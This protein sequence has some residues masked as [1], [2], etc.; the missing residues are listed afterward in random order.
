MAKV[1]LVSLRF[2]VE[3]LYFG[4][5]ITHAALRRSQTRGACGLFP[6]RM[7]DG[8]LADSKVPDP[9]CWSKGISLLEASLI[10]MGFQSRSVPI[11]LVTQ[12]S[13]S[14]AMQR[15]VRLDGSRYKPL[16][17]GWSLQDPDKIQSSE[18][19]IYSPQHPGTLIIL[20]FR[21][22]LGKTQHP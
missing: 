20:R 3:L 9:W 14:N 6:V 19:E 18:Q 4:L 1:W 7:S 12:L 10:T 11:I 5:P 21:L 22:Q 16:T 8:V 15:N 13:I 17:S 2:R